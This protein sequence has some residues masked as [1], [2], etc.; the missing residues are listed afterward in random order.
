MY[1]GNRKESPKVGR[2]CATSRPRFASEKAGRATPAHPWLPLDGYL[3][4][5][6]FSDGRMTRHRREYPR[7]ASGNP[8]ALSRS[9]SPR[10]GPADSH[11]AP[12]RGRYPAPMPSAGAWPCRLRVAPPCRAQ[13]VH[14][15]P[16]SPACSGGPCPMRGHFPRSRRQRGTCCA[17]FDA[18]G[19]RHAGSAAG[20]DERDAQDPAAEDKPRRDGKRPAGGRSGLCNASGFA[21]AKTLPFAQAACQPVCIRDG[22]AVLTGRIP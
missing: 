11:R 1:V 3:A 22:A 6:L 2:P 14:A 7:V 15:G 4:S 8:R 16:I 12:G 21:D 5:A 20:Y 17:P 19:V 18:G 13:G 9:E 10:H